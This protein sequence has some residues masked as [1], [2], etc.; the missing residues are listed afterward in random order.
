MYDT[1]KE[2]LLLNSFSHENNVLEFI[3]N[4]D[5]NIFGTIAMLSVDLKKSSVQLGKHACKKRATTEKEYKKTVL[6]LNRHLRNLYKFMTQL[7][8]LHQNIVFHTTLLYMMENE[9]EYL[10]EIKTADGDTFDGN[11]PMLI[12]SVAAFDSTDKENLLLLNRFRNILCHTASDNI[13][14]LLQGDVFDDILELFSSIKEARKLLDIFHKQELTVLLGKNIRR[15]ASPELLKVL[16]DNK[17]DPSAVKTREY[18]EGD[19]NV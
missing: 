8:E 9:I 3:K 11:F 18:L 16:E 14:A 1:L 12:R 2:A 15:Y 7:N 17:N 13:S 5:R 4:S 6:V 19:I 10:N